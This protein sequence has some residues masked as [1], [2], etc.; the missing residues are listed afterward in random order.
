MRAQAVLARHEDEGLPR[1][2]ALCYTAALLRARAAAAAPRGP[3]EAAALHAMRRAIA[4]NSHVPDYLLELRALTLPPE[5][6]LSL[7]LQ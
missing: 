2:A 7:S 5:C 6:S 3:A 1:S 4:Y